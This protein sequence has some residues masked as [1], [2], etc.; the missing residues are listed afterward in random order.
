MKRTIVDTE[1]PY[2]DGAA[3]ASDAKRAKVAVVDDKKV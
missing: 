3:P 1:G 2:P